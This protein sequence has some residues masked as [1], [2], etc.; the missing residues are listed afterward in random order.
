MMMTVRFHSLPFAL[1]VI[2]MVT[3]SPVAHVEAGPHAVWSTYL[4]AEDSDVV[5][6]V[7]ADSSGNVYVTGWT[8]SPNHP[9][10]RAMDDRIGGQIDC[11]VTKF[12]PEGKIA[13]R[14][15]Y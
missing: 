15:D 2:A 13:D 4:G 9:T 8:R 6:A 1:A 10:R 5:K 12:D 14:S 3:L 7:A 11:F